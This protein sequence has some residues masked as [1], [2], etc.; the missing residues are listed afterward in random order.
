MGRTGL[1]TLVPLGPPDHHCAKSTNRW[2]LGGGNDCMHVDRA[3]VEPGWAVL[4]AVQHKRLFESWIMY[5][6]LVDMMIQILNLMST[7]CSVKIDRRWNMTHETEMRQRSVSL[8]NKFYGTVLMT[9][10]GKVKL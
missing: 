5:G 9:T 8:I 7:V 2:L 3:K 6:N 1:G 4:R 10:I